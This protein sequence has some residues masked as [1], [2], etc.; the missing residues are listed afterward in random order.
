MQKQRLGPSL[1]ECPRDKSVL[2]CVY[3]RR[4]LPM[5]RN[6]SIR[7]TEWQRRIL[8]NKV[9]LG[10]IG[11]GGMGTGYVKNIMNGMCPEIE[12]AA[13]ADRKASRRAVCH[14]AYPDIPL[15]EEGSDLIA[16]GLVD[17]VHI[18]VPHYQHP[19]LAID[20]FRHGLHVLCEKPAGVYTLQ[21]RE[22][23]EAAAASG[24]VF[25]LMFNQRTNCIYRKMKEILVSGRLGEIKRVNWIITDWYRT[26]AYYD[27]GSWR[28]T[29]DGEGGGVLL[30]QCPHQLDLLQW[31]CGI[32]VKVHAHLHYGKWHDIEVE[33]DVTAYMEFPNG[34]TGV[35]VSTTGDY[36]GSNR[37]E[38]T[39]EKGKF[40]CEHD[41]L[42]AWELEENE[43][44]WCK[45]SQDGFGHIPY[46]PMELDM[47]DKNPQHIGIFNNFA[48][49][50][51]HGTP[52]VAEGQEG[53]N[54]LMLSNAFHLSDW[55]G[56]SVTIP[57]DE[58][59][60]LELLTEKRKLSAPKADSDRILDPSGTYGSV[61]RL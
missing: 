50:I 46:H 55:L 11:Y 25:A 10:I 20:A 17:A 33:D 8:M 35:F 57:F 2:E 53:I 9:R 38:I 43:R 13:I 41:Q 31:L 21:V 58:E 51:L 27:S 18:V 45:Q 44:V 16:S 52:L 23:N 5:G 61:V 30:N 6:T 36:P 26:Q 19:T 37:L 60:F 15:F 24:K 28:A 49:C 3:L 47:D 32:P 14:E 29:W 4:V 7:E 42:F 48:S 22:M 39:L 59:K 54:S 12:I 40:L 34:A 56:E 1:Y